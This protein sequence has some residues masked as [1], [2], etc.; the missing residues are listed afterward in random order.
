MSARGAVKVGVNHIVYI[1]FNN[2]RPSH[3]SLVFE[4]FQKQG[5]RG[6]AN[7]S[8]QELFPSVVYPFPLR[9]LQ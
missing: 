3:D 9:L 1:Y 2:S 7:V 4:I 6:E 8:C 5:M